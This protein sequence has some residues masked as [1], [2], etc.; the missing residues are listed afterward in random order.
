GMAR[1]VASVAVTPRRFIAEKKPHTDV[2][3][4]TCLAYYLT[5]MR[6]A[7]LFKTRDITQLNA[8]AALPRLSNPA[9]TV[10]N[11]TQ[12]NQFLASVGGGKKQ[13]TVRGEALVEA[14]PERERVTEALAANPMVG[15]KRRGA[16]SRAKGKKKP[17][18]AQ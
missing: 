17:T 14:L 3:R 9:F 5:H 4:V 2:E 12:Q 11:A 15:R 18:G 6:D 13:I 1:P 8:E 16:K 7:P 10:R